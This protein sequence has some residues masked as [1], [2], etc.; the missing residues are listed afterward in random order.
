MRQSRDELTL[1]RSLGLRV[2]VRR[3]HCRMSQADLAE[4]AGIDRTHVS[5]VERGAHNVTVLTLVQI[6][7]ALE[8][9]PGE[10]LDSAIAD[11]D[12]FSGLRT[13]NTEPVRP[14][15]G[16]AEPATRSSPLTASG[17]QGGHR[18]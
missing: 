17:R 18:R 2:K 16:Q 13:R 6:A 4:T 14:P 7:Q 11:D 8:V 15:A 9:P 3:T 10:L 12:R 1:P 5:R